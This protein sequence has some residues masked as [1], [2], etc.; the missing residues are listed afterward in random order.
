MTFLTKLVTVATCKPLG[1]D[2][3]RHIYVICFSFYG[4]QLKV[5]QGFASQRTMN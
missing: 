5:G 4:V 3:H 2:G 1:T